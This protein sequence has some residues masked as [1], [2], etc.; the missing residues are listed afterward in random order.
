[1]PS[2]WLNPTRN[3]QFCQLTR[4]PSRVNDGPCGWVMCSGSSG[5]RRLAARIRSGI[6]LGTY[7]PIT[8]GA[9]AAPAANGPSSSTRSNCMLLTS[10]TQCSPLTRRAY[11]FAPGAALTQLS[12]H[13]I[14]RSRNS[15]GATASP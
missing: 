14:L 9:V 7:S 8:S 2:R 6:W 13:P 11:G 1:M 3:D 12:D 10:M 15:G 4:L 5:S